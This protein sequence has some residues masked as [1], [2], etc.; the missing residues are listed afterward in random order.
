VATRDHVLRTLFEKLLPEF[1][2]S[3][4]ETP[5]DLV[6]QQ[7]LPRIN[8]SVK[9]SGFAWRSSLAGP[10]EKSPELL[11]NS[12]KPLPNRES[13]ELHLPCCTGLPALVSSATARRKP[14]S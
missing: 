3:S 8:K 14:G 9:T 7:D 5:V 1:A 10:M 4:Q 2:K 12:G 11:R 13:I 6:L